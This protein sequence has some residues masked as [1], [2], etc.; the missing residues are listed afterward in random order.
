M[1]SRTLIDGSK[2]TELEEAII[3][4]VYTKV[5]SKWIL[6]DSETGAKYKGYNH[7]NDPAI[8]HWKKVIE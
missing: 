4:K 7:K 8:L 1:K 3:L 2:A 6:T 5:P